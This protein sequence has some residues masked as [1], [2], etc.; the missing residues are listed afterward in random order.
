M[1]KIRFNVTY[2]ADSDVLYISRRRESATRGV[3]DQHGIVWRYGR[4]GNLIGAT[5]LDFH[6]FW[7]GRGDE[8]AAELSRHFDIPIPQARVVI[9]HALEQGDG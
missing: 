7:A 5:I 3:E 2:D 6:E 9:D 4:D 1:S 8:L